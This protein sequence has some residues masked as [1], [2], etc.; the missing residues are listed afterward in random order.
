MLL[1]LPSGEEEEGD[2]AA[3]AYPVANAS[4]PSPICPMYLNQSE[5]VRLDSQLRG[6]FQVSDG[7]SNLMTNRLDN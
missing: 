3:A 5:S 7:S 2:S 6:W 1:N 4:S